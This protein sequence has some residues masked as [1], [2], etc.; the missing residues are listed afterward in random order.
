MKKYN[1]EKITTNGSG[2]RFNG[3]SIKG[4]NINVSSSMAKKIGDSRVQLYIDKNNLAI[5]L[6]KTNKDMYAYKL[7]K[8]KEG[9]SKLSCNLHG[10]IPNGRYLFKKEHNGGFLLEIENGTLTDKIDSV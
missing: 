6:K 10:A 7:T 1:F 3:I 4:K 8:G 2:F 9:T 5:L